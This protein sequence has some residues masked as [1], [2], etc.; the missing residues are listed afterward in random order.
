[1]LANNRIQ[2]NGH[3]SYVWGRHGGILVVSS[4]NADI[5]GNTFGSN[6]PYGVDVHDDARSPSVSNV[7]IHDNTMNGDALNGCGLSGVGCQNN[8]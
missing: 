2:G 6:S 4:Q 1:L 7:S 3:A 8:P 5:F